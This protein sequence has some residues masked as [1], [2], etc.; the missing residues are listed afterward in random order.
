MPNGVDRN[1]V[2]YISC[3]SGFKNKFKHWPTRIR[4]DSQFIKELNEVMTHEDYLKMSQ[5]VTLIS[6][7]SNPWDGIYIAEDDNGNT[8]D[9][10][11]HG[12]GPGR[13]DDV[14]NWFGIKWPNYGED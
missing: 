8:Y 12:H 7:D 4:L 13:H 9:L 11:R 10:M 5:K 2:R 6:D 14:L 3:I 1:F